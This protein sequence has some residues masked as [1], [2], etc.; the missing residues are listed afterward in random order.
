MATNVYSTKITPQDMLSWVNKSLQYKYSQIEELCTGVAYCQLI[1]KLY[2]ESVNI[3]RVK[4]HAKLEHGYRE[5]FKMLQEGFKKMN[6]NKTLPIDELI[7]GRFQE[8]FAFLKWFIKFYDNN[9]FAA[10]LNIYEQRLY[11]LQKER[12]FHF[13]KLRRIEK[14]CLDN[15]KPELAQLVQDMLDIIYKDGFVI[16]ES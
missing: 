14:F 1:H 15:K 6:I 3:N 9:E 5:N 16:P 11:R 2:P 12:N 10:E 13:A 4:I 7:K 8:H